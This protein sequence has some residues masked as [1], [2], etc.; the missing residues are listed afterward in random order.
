MSVGATYRLGGWKRCHINGHSP[1][2]M[3]LAPSP[4]IPVLMDRTL[5]SELLDSTQLYLLPLSVLPT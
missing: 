4:P 2:L 1:K 3:A 5:E